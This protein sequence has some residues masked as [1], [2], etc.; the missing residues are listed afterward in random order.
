M[1]ADIYGFTPLNLALS[2]NIEDFLELYANIEHTYMQVVDEHPSFSLTYPSGRE[3][4]NRIAKSRIISDLNRVLGRYLE[5]FGVSNLEITMQ[6][7]HLKYF[8]FLDENRVRNIDFEI[9]MNQEWANKGY[10]WVDQKYLSDTNKL[11]TIQNTM[12]GFDQFLD[13]FR[14][15]VMRCVF[16]EKQKRDSTYTIFH[17]RRDIETSIVS[18]MKRSHHESIISLNGKIELTEAPLYLYDSLNSISCKREKHQIVPA[19]YYTRHM[20]GENAIVLPVHFCVHCRKYLCG[21]ISY[22]LFKL[23]FGRVGIITQELSDESQCWNIH[24]ESMLHQ[25][26][27]NVVEGKMS[28]SERQ[29]L[30]VSILESKQLTFFEIVATI[31]QDIRIFQTNYRMKNAVRKWKEDLL[32]VNEYMASKL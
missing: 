2:G 8:D 28:S 6:V 25:L 18:Y 24:G 3:H 17:A 21:R 5:I 16:E 32:F 9:R 12:I 11:Y 19:K 26:G 1:K 23:H 10:A 31:E 22:S 30:L 29:N 7:S 15:A 14:R 13:Y 4:I 20:D 27:Y